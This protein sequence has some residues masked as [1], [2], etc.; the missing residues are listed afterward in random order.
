MEKMDTCIKSFPV[1]LLCH[2]ENLKCKKKSKE[3]MVKYPQNVS[4]KLYLYKLSQNAY[5]TV[6]IKFYLGPFKILS[7]LHMIWIVTCM[8]TKT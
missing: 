4:Y 3:D 8:N 1:D 6:S 5:L 2:K 7:I